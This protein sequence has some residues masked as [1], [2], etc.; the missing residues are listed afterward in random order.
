MK[1]GVKGKERHLGVKTVLPLCML[2]VPELA[3]SLES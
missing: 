2:L 3:P 1:V